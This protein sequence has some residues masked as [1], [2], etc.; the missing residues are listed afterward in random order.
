MEDNFV[1]DYSERQSIPVFNTHFRGPYTR[2]TLTDEL[3]EFKEE[4]GAIVMLRN[5]ACMFIFGMLIV[6]FGAL[7]HG[8]RMFLLAIH[9][10]LFFAQTDYFSLSHS[11]AYSIYLVVGDIF[12]LKLY[13]QVV[14]LMLLI[15]NPTSDDV[16][17]DLRSFFTF[18]YLLVIELI[19]IAFFFFIESI[20]ARASCY[21]VSCDD[22]FNDYIYARFLINILMVGIGFAQALTLGMR[23]ARLLVEREKKE[24][25]VTFQDR[26]K[27]VIKATVEEVE[28]QA[29]AEGHYQDIISLFAYSFYCNELPISG[30][31][32]F[33]IIAANYFTMRS[34]LL[35]DARRPI[36][37]SEVIVRF[38]QYCRVIYY[39]G[40][41]INIWVNVFLLE[42]IELYYQFAIEWAPQPLT[43][44]SLIVIKLVILIVYLIIITVIGLLA[45][46]VA[47]ALSVKS[48][49]SKV[50]SS[51]KGKVKSIS[52]MTLSCRHP[53]P[54][55]TS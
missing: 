27:R 9:E 6:C 8:C 17:R 39:L 5:L 47:L 7:F 31:I 3:N 14:D 13:G 18:Y 41:G 11:V 23:H 54:R 49:L 20:L 33:G 45:R 32:A 50:H 48:L 21:S 1:A 26:M 30:I 12:K 15:K 35:Y 43:E 16:E 4:R 25:L 22:E 38:S 24:E 34:E 51:Q 29:F 19:P 2:N 44:D 36:N 52:S 37:K 42:Y 28:R 10:P 40:A 46:A 55:S 53:R